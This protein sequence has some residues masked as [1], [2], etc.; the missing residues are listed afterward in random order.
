MT[1]TE[2]A[3]KALEWAQ[4]ADRAARLAGKHQERADANRYGEHAY[5]RRDRADEL[6]RATE[7]NAIAQ[8]HASI[9]HLW[10]AV[11]GVLD[12]VTGEQS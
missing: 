10:V 2:A 5:Q 9:A 1:R 3:A 6:Q 12:D 4:K 8:Q 7:C 11:A